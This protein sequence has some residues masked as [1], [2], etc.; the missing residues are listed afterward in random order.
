MALVTPII[1]TPE[2]I[3]ARVQML[4]KEIKPVVSGHGKTRTAT[5]VKDTERFVYVKS[6]IQLTLR[7]EHL[8]GDVFVNDQTAYATIR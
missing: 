4:H 6:S 1:T 8:D 7:H 2:A 5:Y 3:I